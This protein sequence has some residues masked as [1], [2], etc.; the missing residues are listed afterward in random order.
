[1]YY[2]KLFIDGSVLIIFID[3]RFSSF[4]FF[5]VIVLPFLKFIKYKLT[6]KSFKAKAVKKLWSAHVR[7]ILNYLEYS[8]LTCLSLKLI[9]WAGWYVFFCKFHIIKFSFLSIPKNSQ[10]LAANWAV[11]PPLFFTISFSLK[12]ISLSF[13]GLIGFYLSPVCTIFSPASSKYS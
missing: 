2:Q 4:S 9:E 3:L 6:E 5:L 8:L 13:F 12:P 7:D 11:T 1:M 10:T